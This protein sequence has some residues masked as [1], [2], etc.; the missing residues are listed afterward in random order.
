MFGYKGVTFFS[1][2]I[3]IIIVSIFVMIFW[4]LEFGIFLLVSG[5]VLFFIDLWGKKQK[6]NKK[7]DKIAIETLEKMHKKEN[8]E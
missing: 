6:H 5:V 2:S 7:I 8:N 4:S 3:I 1:G